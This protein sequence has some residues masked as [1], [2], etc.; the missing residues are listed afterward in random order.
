[1]ETG[2]R[3]WFRRNGPALAAAALALLASWGPPG[4][5]AAT[6]GVRRG[7]VTGLELPRYVSLGAG[8]A[9]LRVGPGTRYAIEWVYVRRGIP[10]EIVAEYGNWRKVRD[11]SGAKGWMHHSLLS[12]RRTAIVAPWQSEPV[13]LRSGPA[14]ETIALLAPG[15]ISR[16]ERCANGS[17]LVSVGDGAWRGRVPQAKLWG[18]YPGGKLE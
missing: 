10:L 6:E 3:R 7:R 5:A 18:V 9:R 17:C 4:A 15:V 8:R 13:P 16:L 14:Q 1:M 12:G 11:W 2:H